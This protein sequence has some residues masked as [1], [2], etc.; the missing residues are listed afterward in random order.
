VTSRA[1]TR[2]P[3]P[4]TLAPEHTEDSAAEDTVGGTKRKRKKKKAVVGEGVTRTSSTTTTTSTLDDS[5]KDSPSAEVETTKLTETQ[6]D[7]KPRKKKRRRK[8]SSSA[9]ESAL[10]IGNPPQVTIDATEVAPEE[11]LTETSDKESSLSVETENNADESSV[12]S[13]ERLSSETASTDISAGTDVEADKFTEET[14]TTGI[15]SPSKDEEKEVEKNVSPEKDM[16]ETRDDLAERKEEESEDTTIADNDVVSVSEQ[17]TVDD[18]A[19][20]IDTV[21]HEEKGTE[22]T[23]EQSSH[24]DVEEVVVVVVDDEPI[25]KENDGTVEDEEEKTETVG[26]EASQV[27]A[28]NVD[29]DDSITEENIAGEE[30]QDLIEHEEEKTDVVEE[31]SSEVNTIADTEATEMEEES[32]IQVDAEIVVDESITEKSNIDKESDGV[33]EI[34]QEESPKVDSDAIEDKPIKEENNDDAE[35]QETTESED[36]EDPSTGHKSPDEGDDKE[37]ETRGGLSDNHD[38]DQEIS[39]SEGSDIDPE[40]DVVS[41]IEEVLHENV[42]SWIEESDSHSK[43]VVNK[44]RGGAIHVD[45]SVLEPETLKVDEGTEMTTDAGVSEASEIAED[46]CKVV[47]EDSEGESIEEPKEEIRIIDRESLE[48]LEDKNSDAVV[49]VVTWNLAEDSPSEKDAAFIRKFTKNGV[50]PDQGSDIVLISGQEC[51]NIKPRRSEGRRSREYRRLMIKMLGKGYVPLALHLLGGIQFGLFAK[52]SILKDIEDISVVDVTTGIGNV[53]HNKG[54][55]AAFVKLK[56]RNEIGNDDNKKRSK[57]LRMVFVAAH[58][59]AHVKNAESRDADFWRI[60]SELEA[61]AP[62]GFLP[63]KMSNNREPSGSFLFDTVDRVFFCGDLNYRLDLPRELTEHSI[64]HG[65]DDGK[66]SIKDLLRHDQLIHSMAEGRAFPGF[67]EGKI[68]FMPTFK[69]DKESSSYDTS[70]KQRIP[71]WTDRI[72]FQPT[73]DIRVVEYQSIPGAQSSDHR[74]VY[75]SYRIG[76]EGRVIPPSLGKRKRKRLNEFTDRNYY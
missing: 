10:K 41:F 56:A 38:P 54:C 68:T 70:H 27:D 30:N 26:E 61:Q 42:R 36:D 62:E 5:S 9:L 44:T 40:Q 14:T 71:A 29:D 43:N 31:E 58:L 15:S 1:A 67:G 45:D 21:D 69:Y 7:S 28:E 46:D 39:S 6:P 23:E 13:S 18:V 8:K 66:A 4:A 33:T 22:I 64:L 60:S 12:V 34:V 72:L 63:R 53:L 16:G 51:E 17:S 73:E 47:I 65:A 50:S 74:P 52:R 3:D 75:G 2:I 19:K 59:A 55:I 20:S 11:T 57:S 35:I 49:S 37:D 76:M 48:K 24:V 25:A 32:A